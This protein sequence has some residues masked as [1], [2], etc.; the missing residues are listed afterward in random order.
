MLSVYQTILLSFLTTRF[1]LGI[2]VGLVDLFRSIVRLFLT[3][4]FPG[5]IT[6]VLPKLDP[7]KPS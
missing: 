4:I 1:F 6:T 5:A 3:L 2:I 7:D